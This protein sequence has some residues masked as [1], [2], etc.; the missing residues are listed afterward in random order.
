M[1]SHNSESLF[2]DSLGRK[3]TCRAGD[4]VRGLETVEKSCNWGRCECSTESDASHT[5]GFG[6][7]LRNDQVR[8]LGHPFSQR[9]IFGGK[10]DICFVENDNAVPCRVI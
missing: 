3:G 4:V 9:S 10:V 5:K 8:K 7:G 1:V 6:E 2:G